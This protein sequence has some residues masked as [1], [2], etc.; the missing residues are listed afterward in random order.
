MAENAQVEDRRG[1]ALII[2]T[3]PRTKHIVG[4]S[5]G[6]DSQAAAGLVL[7]QHAPEEVILLN[8]NAGENEHPLTVAHVEWYSANVHPIVHCDPIVADIWKTEG[9]AERKGLDGNQPLGFGEMIAIKKRPPSRKAQFCTKILKLQPQKRW[10]D[11]AFGPSGPYSGKDFIRYTGV[12]RDESESRK[13]TRDK[14]WDDFFDCETVHIVAAWSKHECFDFVK[15]RG[16]QVNPLY[17][18]GFGRVGCAPCINSNKD[19][20]ANWADRFPEMIDKV[21]G[22]EQTSGYT[23]FMPRVA[24]ESITID[25]VVK[26]ARTKRGGVKPLLPFTRSSC[27]SK[28][29]LCE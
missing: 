26:W 27:E 25:E 15:S 17:A 18:L 11:W 10:L 6:I 24:G 13:D 1:E 7:S 2:Q 12:R 23:F 9:F 14:E 3:K 5:G 8:S 20:I 16:E 29:G 21:R 28:Y 19:D 22:W 4:F